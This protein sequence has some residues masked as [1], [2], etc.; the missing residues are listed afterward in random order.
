MP[1]TG[2]TLEIDPLHLIVTE[3][4]LV[5]SIYGSADPRE[6]LPRLVDEVGAGRLQLT[7]LVGATY[8]LDEVND[9]IRASLNGTPGRAV[10]CP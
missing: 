5:G 7:P 10:V 9:A 6:A 8:T 2:T 3:K 1:P 4:A